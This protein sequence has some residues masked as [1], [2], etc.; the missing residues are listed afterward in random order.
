MRRAGLGLVL[1]LAGRALGWR[2]AEGGGAER[3]C[4]E[5]LRAGLQQSARDNLLRSR[6]LDADP[7][8]G[9]P[10][11][12]VSVLVVGG[13]ADAVEAR[14][15]ELGALV[16]RSGPASEGNPRDAR[17]MASAE[18]GPEVSAAVC[19][20]AAGRAAACVFPGLTRVP[21]S[22]AWTGLVALCLPERSVVVCGAS[23]EDVLQLS[24]LLSPAPAP[25]LLSPPS[26]APLAGLTVRYLDTHTL[27]AAPVQAY[28]SS[29]LRVAVQVLERLGATTERVRVSEM[30]GDT[31]G[32]AQVL[33]SP[34]QPSA[35][36]LQDTYKNAP[37]E[38][39]AAP[40]Y[41]SLCLP[42]GC[43]VGE[44]NGY[45]SELNE[46]RGAEGL[47]LAATLSA[48]DGSDAMPRVAR[49]YAEATRWSSEV[50]RPGQ[51]RQDVLEDLDDAREAF[52]IYFQSSMLL[53]F[54]KAQQ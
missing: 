45:N 47:P 46:L 10:L 24:A 6:R 8:Q 51:T 38:P 23:V 41:P 28:A 13:G 4:R 2:V 37:R 36:L 40:P 18:D 16:W 39:Y 20:L 50:M 19:A 31:M 12:G 32:G 33:L 22:V 11:L 27:D 15:E 52:G 34:A 9:A 25:P 48:L 53:Y 49:A 14:L 43:V 29:A 26:S 35:A 17:F 44:D 5:A 1:L 42:A 7:P 30:G 3:V 21:Q 54:G